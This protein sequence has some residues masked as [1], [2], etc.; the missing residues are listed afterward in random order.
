[1]LFV[2]CGMGRVEGCQIWGHRLANVGVKD[3]GTQAVVKGC[4]CA[5]AW[6]CPVTSLLVL[7]GGV[8]TLGR[9]AMP[10]LIPLSNCQ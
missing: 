2:Q 5:N 7:F 9:S 8:F 6:P 4:E 3:S 10:C 1:M